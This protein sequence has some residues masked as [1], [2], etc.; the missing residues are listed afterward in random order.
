[1]NPK[2]SIEK[3]KRFEKFICSEI[4]QAGLGEA[5]R[6]SGSGNGLKKGDVFANIPFLIEAKNEKA[7]IQK[8]LDWIDQAKSQAEIGNKDRN[9]WALAFRDPRT[10]EFQDVYVII[11]LWEFLKLMKK[12]SEPMIQE[13]DRELKYYLE[14]LKENAKQII[15]RL[16]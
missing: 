7:K 11:D 9:K 13:A 10:G 6:E 16:E 15:K 8:V 4:E 1:M 2:S 5:R 14:R 3:G 12:D